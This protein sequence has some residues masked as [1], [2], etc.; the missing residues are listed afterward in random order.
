MPVYH[1]RFNACQEMI[2]NIAL[3]PIKTN[4]KGPALKMDTNSDEVDIID[5][6]ILY[7]KPNIF[8]REFEIKGP[9]DRTMIYLILYISEC[10]RK[11]TKCQDR[12][13]AQK[14]LTML[15]LNQ[16]IPIPGDVDFPLNAMYKAP[17][18]KTET[19]G[20]RQYLQ[21][22]RQE[23]GQRLIEMVYGADGTPSKWWMCF[24]KKRFLEKSLIRQGVMI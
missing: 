23:M 21:Q 19:E 9:G 18:N 8:F 20:M 5:E 15:A 12:I 10:L 2:G 3:L 1:S 4:F 6:A 11:I 14:D 7:F 16:K 24:S 17:Q 22:L 13:Q